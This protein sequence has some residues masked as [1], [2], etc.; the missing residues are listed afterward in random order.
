M[1]QQWCCLISVI[2]Q[3]EN[4][5][6]RLSYSSELGKKQI[7]YVGGGFKTKA[8]LANGRLYGKYRFTDK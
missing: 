6:I 8:T 2:L 7:I 5:T 4:Y 1:G 3:R